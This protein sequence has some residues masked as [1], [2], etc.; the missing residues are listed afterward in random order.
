MSAHRDQ[1]VAAFER[2][3]HEAV[4]AAGW[5]PVWEMCTTAWAPRQTATAREMVPYAKLLGD[6]DPAE[7]LEAL[8]AC[9]GEWRPTPGQIR[10]H[11]NGR[12][13]DS[14]RVDAGRGCSREMHP[15]TLQ[16]VADRRRAGEHVCGCDFHRAQWDREPGTWVRRCPE[17]GGLEPGQ[18]FGAEDV[19]LLEVAA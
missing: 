6:H 14:S 15:E 9:A 4:K 5:W 12:R 11:L 19:G 3:D 13:S 17:C 10:G 16:D 18:V 7:V 8:E 2:N 1:I